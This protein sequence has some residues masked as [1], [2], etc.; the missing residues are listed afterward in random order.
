MKIDLGKVRIRFDFSI[1][2]IVEVSG[3]NS[4]IDDTNKN[5][6]L[7]WDFD[8]VP[9]VEVVTSLT[10]VQ[11]LYSLPAI[12]V[13]ESSPLHY[14]AYCFAIRTKA[15]A[16]YIL[17]TTPHIDDVFFRLGVVR[18]YWTLR[19]TP[20]KTG[21]SFRLVVDLPSTIPEADSSLVSSLDIV[22]YKTGVK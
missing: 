22:K 6:I 21:Q 10:H 4:N 18:S 1:S 12:H 16:M 2:R 20:K 5:H 8:K 13:I 11:Q 17:S 19:I 15:E 7:L 9:C 3:V 14:H